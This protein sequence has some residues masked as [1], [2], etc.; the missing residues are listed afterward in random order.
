ML[1]VSTH[2]KNNLSK[3]G[4]S[5]NFYKKNYIQFD[6]NEGNCFFKHDKEAITL[7]PVLN[8]VADFFHNFIHDCT[9]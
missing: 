4:I 2:L 8:T 9:I 1:A 5:W 3:E 7:D 6:L